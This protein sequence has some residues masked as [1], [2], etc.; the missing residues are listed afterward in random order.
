MAE[1]RLGNPREPARRCT[2][3]D[4][5]V[6]TG[7]S[8]TCIP[9]TL[10]DGLFR[11]KEI[12]LKVMARIFKEEPTL[13]SLRGFVPIS[14]ET[15][16]SAEDVQVG[17]KIGLQFCNASGRVWYEKK[18]VAAFIPGLSHLIVGT[19]ILYGLA[20]FLPKGG[21]GGVLFK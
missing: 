4:A 21:A 12:H 9:G 10:A 2:V 16:G 17:K 14:L 15:A 8:I 1:L 13:A 7:A 11:A 20:L 6:D 19:D 5:V 3:N 18:L